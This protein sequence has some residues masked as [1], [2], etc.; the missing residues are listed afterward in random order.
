VASVADPTI[1]ITEFRIDG[2]TVVFSIDFTGP[3]D[4]IAESNMYVYDA[5]S[6]LKKYDELWKGPISESHQH[7]GHYD[8]PASTLP[9]GDYAVWIRAWVS[10]HDASSGLDMVATEGTEGLSFLVGRHHVYASAEEAHA[11]DPGKV[12][13]SIAH[14]RLEGTW[15]IFDLVNAAAYDVSVDHSI[16]VYRDGSSF[17]NAAGRELVNG[18]TTQSAHHL[19]PEE[20]PD[21]SYSVSAY[22]Q[23]EGAQE[24]TFEELQFQAH[25]GALTVI[26]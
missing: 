17:H 13:V 18:N 15:V 10:T 20:I 23:V 8:L 21:G 12:K 24:Q 11:D 22:V 3:P 25:D 26:P 5:T 7:A 4:A 6:E 2:Q 9:D 1:S 16:G 19:L 14:L